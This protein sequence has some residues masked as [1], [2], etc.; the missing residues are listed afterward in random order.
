METNTCLK[1][2][3]AIVSDEDE[4]NFAEFECGTFASSQGWIEED[5]VCIRRQRDALERRVRELEA[6]GDKLALRVSVT[7]TSDAA[8]ALGDVERWTKAKGNQ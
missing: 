8:N 1:C 4:E 3:A 5:T 2:G 6:A 7:R